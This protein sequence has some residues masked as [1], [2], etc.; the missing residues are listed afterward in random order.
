[1]E[2]FLINVTKQIAV[3][4]ENQED[5]FKK[6]INGEGKVASMSMSASP[7]PQP[8]RTPGLPTVP[9]NMRT[10]LPVNG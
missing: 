5:A 10:G 7:R 4:A 6:V 2:D 3:K 1:M 9:T 8:P